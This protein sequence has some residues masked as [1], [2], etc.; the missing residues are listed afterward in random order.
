MAVIPGSSLDLALRIDAAIRSRKPDGWRGVLAKE[1]VVKSL[2]HEILHDASR[3]ER[4]FL[5]ITAQRE[6]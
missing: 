3:V 4:L 2:I 6:Y 1:R 5:I